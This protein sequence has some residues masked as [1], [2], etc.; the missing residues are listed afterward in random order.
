MKTAIFFLLAAS[1]AFSQEPQ[2]PKGLY[3]VFTTSAGT[4]TAKL[5]EKDTPESVRTFVGLAQGT[6]AWK[7]PRSG[8]MVKRPLYDNLLF[9]R[10]LPGDMIQSGSPTGTTAYDCGFTIRDEFLPGLRFDHSGALA[11]ANAGSDNTGGCQFFITTGPVPRWNG[12]YAVFGS[13][14]QGMDVVEKI[15]HLPVH[16]EEPVNPA[17]LIHVVINR[18]GPEPGKR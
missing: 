16:G 14:V 10:S 6:K 17:K 2:L 12:K 15:N 8:K 4:F 5:F 13:V 7:D 18:V 1:C 11:M 9:Y 3:A